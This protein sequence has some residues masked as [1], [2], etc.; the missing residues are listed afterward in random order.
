MLYKALVF[1]CCSLQQVL[2]ERWGKAEGTW[3]FS[4]II[5]VLNILQNS[6][7]ESCNL[8]KSSDL[9]TWLLENAH[10]NFSD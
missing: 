4:V 1:I 3:L 6:G 10:M 7:V 5:G 8:R 2:L 9:H